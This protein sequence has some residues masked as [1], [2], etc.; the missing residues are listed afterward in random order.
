VYPTGIPPLDSGLTPYPGIISKRTDYAVNV[1]F[2]LFIWKNDTPYFNAYFDL[3]D[4]SYSEAGFD[5]QQ[6]YHLA[7]VYDGTLPDPAQ[8]ARIYVN[9]AFDTL[10]ALGAGNA[11]LDPSDASVQVG[12]LPGGGTAWIGMIDEVAIWNRALSAKEILALYQATGPL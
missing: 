12:N 10:W 8:R 6:W 11:T 5:N 3:P 7:V 9:G 2:T 4:R 1:A